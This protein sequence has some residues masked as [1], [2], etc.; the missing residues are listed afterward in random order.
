VN[1]DGLLWFIEHGGFRLPDEGGCM[2]TGHKTCQG[3][4]F[5]QVTLADGS[6]VALGAFRDDSALTAR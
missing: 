2:A 1:A 5:W 4:K 6:A 3:W